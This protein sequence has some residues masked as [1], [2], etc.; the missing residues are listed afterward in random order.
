MGRSFSDA[1]QIRESIR[2]VLFALPDET[3]VHTGHGEDTT[4]GAERPRI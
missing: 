4:I 3:V 2:S 1:S